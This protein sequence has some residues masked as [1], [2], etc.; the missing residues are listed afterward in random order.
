M[1]PWRRWGHDFL[2]VNDV[3]GSRIGYVNRSSGAVVIERPELAD[4]FE[5]AIRG[6][7]GRNLRPPRRGVR[8]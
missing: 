1:N 3:D 8:R 4:L 5:S 6:T 2:Y 7:M